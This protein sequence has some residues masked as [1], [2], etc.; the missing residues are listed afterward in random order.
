[1]GEW[2]AG[3]GSVN[4]EVYKTHAR[5]FIGLQIHGVSD[6]ELSLP[7]HANSGVTARQPLVVKWRNIR[8]RPLQKSR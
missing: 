5:G 2:P 4:E 8:I 6:R 1:M 7:L 3:R